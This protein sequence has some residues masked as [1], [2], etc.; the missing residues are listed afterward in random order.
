VRPVKRDDRNRTVDVLQSLLRVAGLLAGVVLCTTC[1]PV[2]F[3]PVGCRIFV[4]LMGRSLNPGGVFCVV[5]IG[6]ADEAVRNK[7]NPRNR[8]ESWA[9]AAR[10]DKMATGLNTTSSQIDSSA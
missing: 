9:S 2:I 5:G 7:E 10:S 8:G 6:D 1:R 4:Y 3:C